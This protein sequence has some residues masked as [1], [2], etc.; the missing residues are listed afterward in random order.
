MGTVDVVP[1]AVDKDGVTEKCA[2]WARFRSRPLAALPS[3]D[4]L[5]LQSGRTQISI[6]SVRIDDHARPVG[7]A[8]VAWHIEILIVAPRVDHEEGRHVV[9][10]RVR[11][12][13]KP[14]QT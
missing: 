12:P 6:V 1:G 4:L 9:V 3:I 2:C 13:V 5:E 7:G 10:D 11:T 14:D 8:C